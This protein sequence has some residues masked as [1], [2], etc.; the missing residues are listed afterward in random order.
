[1]DE[2]FGELIW[3]N[4]N[5]KSAD[6]R[7]ALDVMIA[8]VTE[9]CTCVNDVNLTIALEYVFRFRYGVLSASL[10]ELIADRVFAL[11]LSGIVR[12]W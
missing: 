6:V 12:T 3:D 4:C 10:R 7:S 8:W 2:S 1:M 11:E 9:H 5:I